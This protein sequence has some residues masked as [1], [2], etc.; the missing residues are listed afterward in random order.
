MPETLI[1][2]TISVV[3]P[4]LNEQECLE[5]FYH[6]TIEALERCQLDG[7]ELVFVD[8]GS[9]DRTPMLLRSL[10]AMNPA[11]KVLTLSRNFGHHPAVFAGLEFASGDA[12]VILDADLQDPPELIPELLAAHRSGCEVVFARRRENRDPFLLKLLKHGFRV[13]MRKL[14]D[15]DF[16][17]NV[18]VFSLMSRSLKELL[19]TMPERERY[20]VAMQMYLGFRVGYVDYSRDLRYGGKSK[21]DLGR[22]FRLGMNSLF[23]YSSLPLQF[24]MMAG[25]LCILVTGG[26][27]FTP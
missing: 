22:L 21:Q 5:P 7:Y 15:I 19:L 1:A 3:S 10:A 13:L 24:S 9:T 14:S 26:A 20:L 6:R 25:M 18:G 16:P 27:G 12:V 4:V 2:R 17:H 11:V 8:D 23:S